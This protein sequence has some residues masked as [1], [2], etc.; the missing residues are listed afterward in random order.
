M[1]TQP[2]QTGAKTSPQVEPRR[3]PEPAA[4]KACCGPAEQISCCAPTAKTGCC[5]D[6]HSEGC[7]C[8]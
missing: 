2:R 8:K 4:L 3:S 1:T 6:S 7:G 5:G